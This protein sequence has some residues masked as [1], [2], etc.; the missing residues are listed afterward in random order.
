MFLL[1]I[2]VASGVLIATKCRPQS[3]C[4]VFLLLVVVDSGAVHARLYCND[5]NTV[6][7]DIA[8]GPLFV[9]LKRVGKTFEFR[10]AVKVETVSHLLM[11]LVMITANEH[12]YTALT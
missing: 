12:E 4:V 1:L 11:L 10:S 5:N 3:V 6:L 8:S 2:I 7:I 9:S